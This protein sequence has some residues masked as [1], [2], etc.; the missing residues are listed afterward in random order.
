MQP[1]C[2]CYFL[3]LV[4]HGRDTRASSVEI[5]KHT[6]NSTEAPAVC[7]ED[8]RQCIL[9]HI[10]KVDIWKLRP[11]GFPLSQV[12]GVCMAECTWSSLARCGITWG[13]HLTGEVPWG[14]TRKGNIPTHEKSNSDHVLEKGHSH[15]NLE[16]THFVK[17]F[18]GFQSTK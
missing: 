12:H 13:R 16:T 6:L 17:L 11:V 5:S 7:C 15:Q 18:D 3:G 1:L 2:G 9:S 14:C 4:K 8:P 10:S